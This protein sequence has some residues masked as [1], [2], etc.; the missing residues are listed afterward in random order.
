M[1]FHLLEKEMVLDPTGTGTGCGNNSI[2]AQLE[3]QEKDLVTLIDS[4]QVS[5]TRVDHVFFP[6]RITATL[7]SYKIRTQTIFRNGH[8]N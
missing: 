2:L 3:V 8:S 7:N 4:L 1:E 5:R 6:D